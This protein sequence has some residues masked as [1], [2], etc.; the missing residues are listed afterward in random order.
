MKWNNFSRRAFY[1]YKVDTLN[2]PIPIRLI[3][4]MIKNIPKRNLQAQMIS[5]ENS[6]KYLNK[7]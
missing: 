4:Y 2:S 6:I 1:Q 3:Q 7:K 5:L